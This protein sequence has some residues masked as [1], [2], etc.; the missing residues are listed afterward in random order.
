MDIY[1]KKR[2]VTERFFE[3]GDVEDTIPLTAHPYY[4][5]TRYPN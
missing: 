5:T 2:F 4:H 3:R 1:H